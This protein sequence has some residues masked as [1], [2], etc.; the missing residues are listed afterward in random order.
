MGSG[1]SGAIDHISSH[2]R[3]KVELP[4]FFYL[5]SFS[6]EKK[7]ELGEFSLLFFSPSLSHEIRERKGH[8]SGP[9]RTTTAIVKK[10]P[11]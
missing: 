1:L 2:G 10:R 11:A 7:Q 9:Q 3:K 8:S 4:G 6:S 5:F